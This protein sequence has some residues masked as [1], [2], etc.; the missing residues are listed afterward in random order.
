M[1]LLIKDALNNV[2]N[3]N[4]KLKFPFSTQYKVK[5]IIVRD[6]IYLHVKI[7]YKETYCKLEMS[8][9]EKSKLVELSTTA[10]DDI[11][12]LSGSP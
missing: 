10:T 8:I 4:N 5:N 7:D 9:C 2:Y 3:F 1:P 6:Y 12:G 11:M